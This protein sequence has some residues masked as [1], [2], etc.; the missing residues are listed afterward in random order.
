VNGDWKLTLPKKSGPA[1]YITATG[2]S[3]VF[4]HQFHP[5]E[6]QI[7]V[8]VY[9]LGELVGSVG[10]FPQYMGRSVQLGA[11]G[12]FA[13]LAWKDRKAKMVEVIVAGPDGKMSFRAECEGQV[14]SPIVAPGGGG[15]LVGLNLPGNGHET[16][17]F[18]KKSG[19]VSSLRLGP[20]PTFLNWLP[21]NSKSLFMTSVG[22]KYRYQLIDW[23]DGKILWD[24]A[25]PASGLW[26]RA[27]PRRA[28]LGDYVL[29]C[30]L[31]FMKLGQREGPVRSV[32]A[33]SLA[34]GQAAAHWLRVPSCH[35][36]TDWGRFAR[37]G[38]KLFL[39]WGDTFSEV[40]LEDITAKKDG[41]R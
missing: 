40:S 6:G 41:W 29:L 18:Y 35:F 30:G 37:Q 32:Y 22:Y 27:V 7:V 14:D 9:T 5:E 36:S 10:P 16:F 39:I 1:G 21:E 13:F 17:I 11:D 26:E 8:D 33:L 23:D 24:V 12:S 25:D 28:V 15:V 4:L 34:N 2:D 3:R 20:N 19:K 38:E 31:E